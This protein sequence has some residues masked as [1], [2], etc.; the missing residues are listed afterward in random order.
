MSIEI[1]TYANKSQ[2][3]F[4]E[5]VNNEFNVP[6]KVL[7]WGTKWNGYSDKSKGVIKHLE[8]KRDDDIVVFLDGFDTK[9]N[10][11]PNDL[12][13]LFK[14]YECR[15]L[16]SKDSQNY[17]KTIQKVIFGS[18]KSYGTANAGMYMGYAK[19][20]QR[21]L[22]DEAE[23]ACKDDQR[24]LNEICERYDFIKIDEDE[25]IFKNIGPFHGNVKTN[26][27]FVS[28][29]GTIGVSRYTR[30]LFE[31]TQFVYMYVL[32]LLI[33]SMGIFPKKSKFFFVLLILLTIF[34]TFFAD[35]S[36]TLK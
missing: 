5:L 33:T 2:G 27:I 28:Y 29:P 6:I 14:S 26:A 10:R 9:I 12:V 19:E 3:M 11:M 23:L 18:C 1:V 24:N 30:G 8:T 22:K 21:V 15:V 35:K 4:E 36:C 34:Y 16:L 20:L 25:R 32:C 31:Y 13:E 17:G 7:G